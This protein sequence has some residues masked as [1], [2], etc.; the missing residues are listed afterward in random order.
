MN[1]DLNR[2]DLLTL[3]RKRD[4]A[5]ELAGMA[6]QERDHL[7]ERRWITKAQ[8]YAAEIGKRAREEQRR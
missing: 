5:W 8:M 3:R 1:E 4:Q 6:R 7:D 2:M